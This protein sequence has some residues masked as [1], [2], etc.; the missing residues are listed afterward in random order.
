LVDSFSNNQ[1]VVFLSLTFD[2]CYIT[3]DFLKS[4]KF[5][6]AVACDESI[7]IENMNIKNYPTNMVI[8]KKGYPIFQKNGSMSQDNINQM[9]DAIIKCL[10]E[11]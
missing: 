7:V 5:K 3:K 11:K 9:Q 10:A 2:Y 6:Y 8:N 1:D 4:H